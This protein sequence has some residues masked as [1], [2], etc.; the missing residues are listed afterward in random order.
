M[1]IRFRREFDQFF[2]ICFHQWLNNTAWSSRNKTIYKKAVVQSFYDKD[3][4][5]H[6]K[7]W[8]GIDRKYKPVTHRFPHFYTVFNDLNDANIKKYRE[9]IYEILIE[10]GVFSNCNYRVYE[11]NN[12]D[13]VE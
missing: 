10:A 9:L 12:C 2:D 7:N 8:G 3:N 11:S 1:D 4:Y 13:V 5:L 6:L